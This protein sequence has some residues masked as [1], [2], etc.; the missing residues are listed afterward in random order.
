MIM[1]AARMFVHGMEWADISSSPFF[2]IIIE[3]S[4]V[5][6]VFKSECVFSG[7]FFSILLQF[8][9]VS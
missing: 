2:Q 3:Q 7:D 1:A 8:P 6:F 9:A 4:E 5:I